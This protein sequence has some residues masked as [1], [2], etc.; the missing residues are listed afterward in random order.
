[1]GTTYRFIADPSETSE[2]LTWFRSLSQ[3]PDEIR[4]D[5][6]YVLYFGDCGPLNHDSAGRID[7]NASPV[8]TIYLPQVRCGV[9]WSVGEVHFLATP[10]RAQFPVLHK[11][12]LAFSKWLA[13]LPC[14]FSSKSTNNEFAYYLEGSIR[15]QDAPVFAFS[16]GRDALQSGRYFVGQNDNEQVLNV[17]CKTLCLRGVECSIAEP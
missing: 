17:L 15:N 12:S 14:V 11:I 2:V 5:Y 9:L 7:S 6:G 10:L 8:V 13:E 3:P 1:M 4:T 16:S